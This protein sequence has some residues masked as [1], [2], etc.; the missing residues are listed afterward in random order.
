MDMRSRRR[1]IWESHDAYQTTTLMPAQRLPATHTFPHLTIPSQR[2]P[3]S[4]ARQIVM[5][6]FRPLA[7]HR[8]TLP[9]LYRPRDMHR[10][11][12]STAPNVVHYQSTMAALHV[13]R[14]RLRHHRPVA[15]LHRPPLTSK[16][17]RR[18]WRCF[19][20]PKA[21]SYCSWWSG[22]REARL[23]RGL[24]GTRTGTRAGA[25]GTSGEPQDCG[26]MLRAS[27]RFSVTISECA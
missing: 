8:E 2:T 27:C 15:N 19:I 21:C 1:A 13:M 18:R 7:Q 23:K 5:V 14:M 20:S 9:T 24:Q 6:D 22:S 16:I 26:L 4:Q 11:S 3:S 12:G 10:I 17:S 25:Q